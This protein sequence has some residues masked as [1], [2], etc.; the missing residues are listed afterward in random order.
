MHAR[1]RGRHSKG[2]GALTVRGLGRM[3]R[4]WYRRLYVLIEASQEEVALHAHGRF[5]SVVCTCPMG[6]HGKLLSHC[7]HLGVH[8]HTHTGKRGWGVGTL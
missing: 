8:T 5:V 1:A 3:P 4:K 7:H 2:P 6:G